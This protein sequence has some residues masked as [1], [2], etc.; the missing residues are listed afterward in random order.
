[1]DHQAWIEGPKWALFFDISAVFRSDSASHEGSH[2]AVGDFFNR[3]GHS[4]PR[5]TPG[6]IREGESGILCAT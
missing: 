3:L 6:Q 5:G 2:E 4:R 1:M